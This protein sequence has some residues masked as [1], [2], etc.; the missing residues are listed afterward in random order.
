MVTRDLARGRRFCDPRYR[1]TCCTT[2]S[3]AKARYA[4]TTYVIL[5]SAS[6]MVCGMFG[7]STA[8]SRCAQGELY[9]FGRTRDADGIVTGYH[10]R[11]APAKVA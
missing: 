9:R 3:R 2:S 6:R 7:N 11:V 4:S 8:A 1:R 10:A 5:R